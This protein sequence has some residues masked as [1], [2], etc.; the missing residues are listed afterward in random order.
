MSKSN[1]QSGGAKSLLAIGASFLML[2][3]AVGLSL[4]GAKSAVGDKTVSGSGERSGVT[5]TVGAV[6]HDDNGETTGNA[7]FHD[8]NNNAKLSIEVSSISIQQTDRLATVTGEVT[9]A[10]GY[11]SQ[12]FAVGTRV[13]FQVDD[14]GEGSGAI[15]D[16]FSFAAPAGSSETAPATRDDGGILPASERGNLVVRGER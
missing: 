2:F 16:G 10:T 11:F 7:T 3:L 14:E 8:R 1:I 9:K 12:G 6:R 4:V 15:P 5:L 13:S